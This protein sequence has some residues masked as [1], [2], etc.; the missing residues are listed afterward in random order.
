MWSLI[1]IIPT[2]LSKQ[3]ITDPKNFTFTIFSVFKTILQ[4]WALFLD[5][6]TTSVTPS[7]EQMSTFDRQS[8][9]SCLKEYCQ[10]C[11]ILFPCSFL[12]FLRTQVFTTKKETQQKNNIM[13]EIIEEFLR[14]MKFNPWLLYTTE[15]HEFDM[16]QWQKIDFTGLLIKYKSVSIL[17]NHM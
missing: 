9:R 10:L 4:D 13:S 12:D 7:L 2:L 8:L 17:L 3:R 16:E 14:D 15:S 1:I 5:N 11:Y 6:S